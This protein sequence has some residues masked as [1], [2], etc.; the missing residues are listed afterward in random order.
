V[1]HGSPLLGELT[2]GP[3]AAVGP[4]APAPGEVQSAALADASKQFF[5]GCVVNLDPKGVTRPG[6]RLARHLCL[7]EGLAAGSLELEGASEAKAGPDGAA[8]LADTVVP[9][10]RQRSQSDVDLTL[11]AAPAAAAEATS[12]AYSGGAARAS[13]VVNTGEGDVDLVA[14]ASFPPCDESFQAFFW[15][16]VLLSDD[17]VVADGAAEVLNKL[18]CN[19]SG[20]VKVRRGLHREGRLSRSHLGRART[21][22]PSARATCRHAWKCSRSCCRCT[23]AGWRSRPSWRPPRQCSARSRRRRAIASV[24]SR[25]CPAGWWAARSV[26]AACHPLQRR[27]RLTL[28]TRAVRSS[29]D[30]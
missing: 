9:I 14:V 23:R 17:T 25:T 20:R 28:R 3:H 5:S 29:S 2:R 16:L 12:Y 4:V 15:R 18:H 24:G 19:F 8:P 1:S 26:C 27:L 30:A 6:F 13:A 11:A 22:R 21:A 10:R 7:S